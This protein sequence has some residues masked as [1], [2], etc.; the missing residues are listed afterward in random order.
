MVLHLKP[1]DDEDGMADFTQEWV[2]RQIV[3]R[4][5]DFVAYP[6]KME[7]TREVPVPPPE[8]EEVDE[9][10]PP[11]TESVTEVMCKSG[12]SGIHV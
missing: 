4:Y 7:V 10:A 2:L 3:K 6:V 9:N 12:Q 11:K 1:A 8:G 5:S